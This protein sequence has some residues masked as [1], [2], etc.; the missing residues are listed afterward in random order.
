MSDDPTRPPRWTLS[1]DHAA[2]VTRR[3]R[4]TRAAIVRLGSVH[5]TTSHVECPERLQ[6]P[7]LPFASPQQT[8]QTGPVVPES[9]QHLV[10]GLTRRRLHIRAAGKVP[11]RGFARTQLR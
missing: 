2:A 10:V 1:G 7:Y 4:M 5:G 11:R 3:R 6:F 8:N 9:K